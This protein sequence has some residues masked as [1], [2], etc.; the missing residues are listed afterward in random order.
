MADAVE[1]ANCTT[2]LLKVD[3]LASLLQSENHAV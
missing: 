3:R 2:A 1:L